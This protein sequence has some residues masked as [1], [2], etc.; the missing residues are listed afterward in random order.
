MKL[1]IGVGAGPIHPY[2]RQFID[3]TW[4]KIDKFVDAPDV[5]KMDARNLEYPENSVEAIYAS[6]LLEHIPT[7][8]I[9]ST[10]R[11]WY[12]VLR[13]GGTLRINVP[14]MEWCARQLIRLS[15]G[16]QTESPAYPSASRIIDI[17]YGSQEGEPEYH[18]TG[19][20]KMTLHEALAD[21]GFKNIKITQEYEAHEMG[22]LIATCDK[23]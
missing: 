15:E 22:C 21:A 14:D 4:I 16:K 10:L 1:Y 6:H 18:Q 13:V 9:Y 23:S 20:T 17:I 11:N 8:D 3:E 19:F 12:F 2:H 7:R 5:V